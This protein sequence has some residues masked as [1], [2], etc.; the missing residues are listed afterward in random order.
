MYLPLAALVLLVVTGGYEF[1]D[2]HGRNVHMPERWRRHIACSVV[3][4]GGGGLLWRLA[5]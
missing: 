2:I 5:G 3:G 4:V 1:V